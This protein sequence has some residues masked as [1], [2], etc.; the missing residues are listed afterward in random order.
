MACH[1]FGVSEAAGGWTTVSTI[2]RQHDLWVVTHQR[3]RQAIEDWQASHPEN[4][5]IRFLFVGK[6]ALRY[7]ENRMLA[8]FQ[9]WRETYLWQRQMLPIVQRVHR[10][11]GFDL[12]HHVSIATWRVASPLSKL[13]VPL[14]WGPVGGGERFPWQC[15][16]ILSAH[17]LLFE[18]IRELG[19]WTGSLS[20]RVRQCARQAAVCVAANRETANLLRRLRGTDA[21]IYQLSQAFFPAS[22]VREFAAL[23][24][25]KSYL[26]P[27]RLFAS[28]NLEA[29]KGVAIAL[30]A[31]AEPALRHTPLHYVIGGHGPEYGHL[32]K[33]ATTLG[34]GQKVFFHDS[35]EATAY[36]GELFKSHICLLPSLRESAGTTLMEAMLAGS[37]PIV[38]GCGGPQDIVS[39]DCGFRVSVTTPKRMA[40]E[41]AAL[42]GRLEANRQWLQ[43]LG[44]AAHCRIASAYVEEQYMKSVQSFYRAA[45][46]DAQAQ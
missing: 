3:N 23:L 19:N 12:V 5:P 21:G 14:I 9:D 32:R 15:V 42:V 22:K 28:G 46:A 1:P 37:V 24:P 16:S 17:S 10:E 2:S 44:Q 18:M 38:A 34:L 31:L 7:S 6:P 35:F 41:I 29:R 8:R 36:R 39:E 20:R 30:L 33:M 25:S 27:L 45:L 11:V 4:P 26:G 13:E 40:G 43:S